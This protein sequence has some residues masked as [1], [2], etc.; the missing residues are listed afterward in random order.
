MNLAH[1]AAAFVYGT[2][3]RLEHEPGAP[4]DL[5]I[6]VGDLLFKAGFVP[7]NKQTLV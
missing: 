2:D 7:E 3:L 4:R 1:L 6:E 5:P